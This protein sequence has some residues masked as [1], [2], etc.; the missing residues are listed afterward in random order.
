[1][2]R[3]DYFEILTNTPT[4]PQGVYDKLPSLLKEATEQ[5]DDPRERDVVLT[6]SLTILSGCLNAIKGRYGKD[7]V[8]PNLFSFIVAPPANGKSSMKYSAK[9]GKSIQ[10]NFE[11]ANAEA[12]ANFDIEYKIW[13]AAAKKN[14]A[15]AGD[16]PKRP[17]YPI[18]FIPGNSSASAIYWLLDES[19]GKAI[20]CETE[21]DSLTGAI[22]Q[23]WGNF[24]HLLRS[25]FQHEPIAMSRKGDSLYLRIENPALSVLLTGTPD[26]V[27]RLIG[28]TED[29]LC[30][31][32]LFYCYNQGLNWIDQTPCKDCIDYSAHFTKLGYKVERIKQELDEDSYMFSLTQEQFK[33]LNERFGKKLEQIKMFEGQGAASA[34]MR[35]GLIGFRI[36]MIL[37]TLRQKD[38]LKGHLNLVCSDEDFEIAMTLIDVYFEHSMVMYSLLPRQSKAEVSPQMRSFYALL[39][40]GE[41]FKRKNADEIG[42]TIGISKRTVGNYIEK[43]VEKGYLTN[44]GFGSYL[45]ERTE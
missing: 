11:K 6:S 42:G 40:K 4:I 21:A 3:N 12:R 34:V 31:R 2:R 33:T 5:F 9:L 7:A 41:K 26:Q 23:D 45:I 35:L 29:G 17:K 24:S 1:M 13:K 44:Q 37:T 14:H 18:L 16:P 20:I 39:P 27:P 19:N 30:S 43:L 36:A 10:D 38:N 15:E 25:A 22:K 28:S 8:G 32:F